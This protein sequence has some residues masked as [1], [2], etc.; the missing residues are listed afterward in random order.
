MDMWDYDAHGT[1]VQHPLNEATTTLMWHPHKRCDAGRQTRDTK[2]PG[3]L[4]G[5]GGV[6]EVDE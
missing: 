5:Q 2:L 4:D 6:F 3:I 1:R